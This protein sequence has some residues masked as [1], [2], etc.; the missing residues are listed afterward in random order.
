MHHFANAEDLEYEAINADLMPAFFADHR[1]LTG[2]KKEGKFCS[3]S[4]M[5]K[6]S[7]SILFG[8]SAARKVL[9]VKSCGSQR[10][11]ESVQ[12]R[13]C[14]KGKKE[15]SVSGLSR[16]MS[17]SGYSRFYSGTAWPGRPT[18]LSQLPVWNGLNQGHL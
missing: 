9:P 4:N 5:T 15:G 12:E 16:P 6:F 18:Q 10:F 17:S 2:K 7:H 3:E 11:H 8:A 13:D 14:D 1:A